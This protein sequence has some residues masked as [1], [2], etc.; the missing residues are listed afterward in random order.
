MKHERE[1]T[2]VFVRTKTEE[3]RLV[4]VCKGADGLVIRKCQSA[5]EVRSE[6]W[7]SENS[8]KLGKRCFGLSGPELHFQRGCP[9]NV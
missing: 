3:I 9:M 7:A 5:L 1:C 6:S 8:W 2:D 4:D